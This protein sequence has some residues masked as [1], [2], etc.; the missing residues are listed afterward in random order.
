M[1]VTPCAVKLD[2]RQSQS[3]LHHLCCTKSHTL[4]HPRSF[5]LSHQRSTI[6]CSTAPA[7]VTSTRRKT[8][9]PPFVAQA[10]TLHEVKNVAN[11]L[12]PRSWLPELENALWC[13]TI[14]AIGDSYIRRLY[15]KF[16]RCGQVQGLQM[17]A[18]PS[19][20]CTPKALTSCAFYA[21]KTSI[22]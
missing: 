11:L 4:L 16:I 21:K 19:V 7:I 22:I 20:L 5:I 3:L 18:F 12:K 6:L 17:V 8:A 10:A 9:L 15:I 2:G 13:S 1:R 14:H